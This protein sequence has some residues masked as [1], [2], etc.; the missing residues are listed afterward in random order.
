MAERQTTAGTPSQI[1]VIRG[2]C[3]LFFR[4][5]DFVLMI[6][7]LFSSSE[8]NLARRYNPCSRIPEMLEISG[9]NGHPDMTRH[10][11]KRKITG[12]R[13]V[14]VKGTG[15]VKMPSLSI[16]A[17]ISVTASFETRIVSFKHVSIFRKYPRIKDEY[18]IT[19]DN[20]VEDPGRGTGGETAR[21]QE[22]WYQG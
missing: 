22:R 2:L 1:P 7:V 13:N 21:I 17:R 14:Q 3:Q 18:N 16:K 15:E 4:K 19:I 10:F 20:K 6:H 9:N 5:R 12:I 8:R 11:N